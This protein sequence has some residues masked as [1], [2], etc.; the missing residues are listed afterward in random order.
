MGGPRYSGGGG[1]VSSGT[2]GNGLGTQGNG[3]GTVGPGEI[4]ETERFWGTGMGVGWAQTGPGRRPGFFGV[5]EWL[6][7]HFRLSGRALLIGK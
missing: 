4:G 6:L 2:Q 5:F 3:L 1:G 7:M